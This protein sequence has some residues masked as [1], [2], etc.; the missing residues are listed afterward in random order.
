MANKVTVDADVKQAVTSG[1]QAF[2]A[3]S[4]VASILTLVPRWDNVAVWIVMCTICCTCTAFGTKSRHSSQRQNV[5]LLLL[6]LSYFP[7]FLP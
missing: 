6:F 7:K 1:L 3:N 4:F 5:N 2:D